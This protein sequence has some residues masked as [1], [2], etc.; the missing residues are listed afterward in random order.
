MHIISRFG[1]ERKSTAISRYSISLAEWQIQRTFWLIYNNINYSEREE[2]IPDISQNVEFQFTSSLNFN[3]YRV[4]NFRLT[5]DI[6]LDK[7]EL[8]RTRNRD[9]W[10]NQVAVVPLSLNGVYMT[11][12]SVLRFLQKHE[13]SSLVESARCIRRY[14]LTIYSCNIIIN[15][16]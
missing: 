7:L 2:D 13:S 4:R 15:N 16:N 5:W 10:R 6:C 14:I 9:T 3:T 8:V 12:I 11:K 1:N